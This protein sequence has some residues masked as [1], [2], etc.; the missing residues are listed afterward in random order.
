MGGVLVG[1]DLIESAQL[2]RVMDEKEK[3]IAAINTFKLKYNA[4][5][6]DFNRATTFW[7]TDASCPISAQSQTRRAITCNG[8]GN[9]TISLRGENGSEQWEMF[10]MWQHLANA[11]LIAGQYSGTRA[12]GLYWVPNSSVGT[13]LPL[14]TFS[15]K[16]AWWYEHPHV[17]LQSSA[18]TPWI[19]YGPFLQLGR[20]NTQRTM[21]DPPF[22]TRQAYSIDKK[23]DD[24][25]PAAGLIFHDWRMQYDTGVNAQAPGHCWAVGG[26]PNYIPPTI[27]RREGCDVS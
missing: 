9:R 23:F 8:N 5:P 1:R 17:T 12:H 20:E 25:M 24:G 14:S 3:H 21:L 13:A 11:G 10:R 19:Y 15:A 2:R 16:T 27:P 7:G 26:P 4:L 18:F 6:G 22:T